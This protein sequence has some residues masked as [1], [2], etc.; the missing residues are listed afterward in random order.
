MPSWKR[1]PFT[2]REPQTVGPNG[3]VRRIL[4]SGQ[5]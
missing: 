2:M 5:R 3:R 1:S 4:A